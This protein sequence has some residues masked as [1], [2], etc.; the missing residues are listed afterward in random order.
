[1]YTGL[2]EVVVAMMRM[3]MKKRKMITM[4]RI[5]LKTEMVVE[6]LRH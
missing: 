1:M 5:V 4:T 6:I 2:V 3:R